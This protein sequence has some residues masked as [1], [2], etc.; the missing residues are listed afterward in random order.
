MGLS[1]RSARALAL[2]DEAATVNV[3]LR[4]SDLL[5]Q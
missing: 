5:I 4:L 3:T 2:N 1:K